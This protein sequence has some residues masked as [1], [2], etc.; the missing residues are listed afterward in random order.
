MRILMSADAYPGLDGGA[1]R[2]AYEIAN[3]AVAWGHEVAVLT[4]AQDDDTSNTSSIN[5][6][7]VFRA[8]G[9]SLARFI[10]LHGAL[11]LQALPLATRL[12]KEFRP[13][14][15]NI[16]TI[17]F[18]TSL[19]TSLAARLQG[20]P[21]ITTMHIGALDALPI[22]YRA[23]S[24][25]Y[26]LTAGRFVLSNSRAVIAV[27]AEVARHAHRLA[28]NGT[29]VKVIPNGVD[30]KHFAFRSPKD[31]PIAPT[32]TFVGR[33][34]YNKGAHYLIDAL[35]TI[36]A[37]VPEAKVLI[38]GDGPMRERLMSQALRLDVHKAV[39]FL[40]MRHDVNALLR[41]STVFVRPSLTEGMPLGVLE[42]MSTGL[43]VVATRVA[44]VPEIVQ[45]GRN[46][47]L[48]EPGDIGALGRS[49]VWLLRHPDAASE[50]GASGREMVE[51]YYSWERVAD[52]T[53][54]FFEE[55]SSHT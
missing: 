46:G 41:R 27:S 5:G 4:L 52:D 30:T 20:T 6:V 21:C 18:I 25:G 24:R 23:I 26:E 47:L 12:I 54:R 11:S 35:P 37:E 43:P 13:T 36:L 15:T 42:A 33:L 29:H 28:P 32:V 34:M 50:M 17:F 53:L 1:S 45:H 55:V 19:T 7:Q 10:G 39:E 16:H 40:G 38:V 44:G 8:K 22:F 2:V 49:V 51:G 48:V 31:I 3:R 9:I 14:I